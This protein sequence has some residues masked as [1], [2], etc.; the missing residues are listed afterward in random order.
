MM[1]LTAGD[2]MI[3]D[4]VFVSAK[5]DLRE[6]ERVF[7][8]KRISGAPVVDDRGALVG[9]VSQTDLVNFHFREQDDL[10]WESGFYDRPHLEG[11][12]L[13][14]G[15]SVVDTSRV[16]MVE[17]VMTPLVITADEKTP[18]VEIADILVNQR[19][20]RIIVTRDRRVVGIISALDLL[21]LLL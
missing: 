10:V 5:S 3:R 4:V 15:F 17:E 1:N 14:K 6:L 21:Q 12:A 7:L 9:V 8:E 20:H 18:I 13:P 16:P 2:V 11:K 19:V